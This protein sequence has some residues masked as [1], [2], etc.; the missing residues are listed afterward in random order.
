VQRGRKPG[1][2]TDGRAA[3][4]PRSRPVPRGPHRSGEVPASDDKAP[5]RSSPAQERPRNSPAPSSYFLEHI[6]SADRPQPSVEIAEHE[7]RSALHACVWS[8]HGGRRESRETRC[9]LHGD[10]QPRRREDEQS[11]RSAAKLTARR[12]PSGRTCAPGRIRCGWGGLADHR[13]VSRKVSPD[14]R[15]DTRW[16]VWLPPIALRRFQATLRVI[17]SRAPAESHARSS[18][19]PEAATAR[20]AAP[21]SSGARARYADARSGGE[22]DPGRGCSRDSCSAG[23]VCNETQGCP[24]R[25]AGFS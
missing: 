4:R 16:P 13:P 8:R 25:R 1:R 10:R 7:A 24:T 17:Q 5:R 23:N 6:E 12:C 18:A 14:V 20:P 19:L 21:A 9:A 22:V 11:R 3:S 2:A 15:H